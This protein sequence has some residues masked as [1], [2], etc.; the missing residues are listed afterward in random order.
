MVSKLISE[1]E[2]AILSDASSD[3]VRVWLWLRLLE[4]G[5]CPLSKLY[6]RW[7]N[8]IH[9]AIKELRESNLIEISV[10]A[11]RA[12]PFP[13]HSASPISGRAIRKKSTVL[14][15]TD[16]PVLPVLSEP[17]ESERSPDP[18]E[19]V[20]VTEVASSPKPTKKPTPVKTRG[21]LASL[22]GRER[23]KAAFENPRLAGAKEAI[24]ESADWA[25]RRYN[26]ARRRAGVKSIPERQLKRNRKHWKAL[27]QWV[28]TEGVSIDTFLDFVYE[29]TRWQKVAFP[30]AAVVAGTWARD[31]WDA[32]GATVASGA[33][34]HAGARYAVTEESKVEKAREIASA[35]GHSLD[36]DT[37]E[38]IIQQAETLNSIP[39]HYTPDPELADV[40]RELATYLK[41]TSDD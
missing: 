30:T 33:R 4:G 13:Y 36:D 9:S 12:V 20:L 40:E 17:I 18:V 38:Y 29:R 3:A 19:P 2:N 1:L 21:K 37:L 8:M 6:N 15:V 27:A 7:P 11:C 25:A 35:A 41:E 5:E 28:V 34:G 24:I 14:P 22:S 31:E 16:T 32:Q 23:S 26:D 10:S 39:R